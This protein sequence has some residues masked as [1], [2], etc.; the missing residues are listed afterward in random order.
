MTH[1]ALIITPFWASIAGAVFISAI[2]GGFIYAW[3]AHSQ[4]DVMQ[5]KLE[6]IEQAKLPERMAGIEVAV[7]STNDKVDDVKIAQ[8]QQNTMQMDI[9][10]K[11]DVLVEQR[12]R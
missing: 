2:C 8:Q 7:K 10:R 6:S 3:D 12:H 9:S 5:S 11:L 4:A 1:K